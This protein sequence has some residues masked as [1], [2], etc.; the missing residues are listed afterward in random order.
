MCRW[1][2]VCGCEHEFLPT[3]TFFIDINTLIRIVFIIARRDNGGCELTKRYNTLYA[4]E[5]SVTR[6]IVRS[7]RL[8][9]TAQYLMLA[10]GC[11]AKKISKFGRVSVCAKLFMAF[12]DGC[13]VYALFRRFSIQLVFSLLVNLATNDGSLAERAKARGRHITELRAETA[14]NETIKYN[15]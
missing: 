14:L 2:C 1:T 6:L 10:A 3:W 9:E 12:H 4:F 13:W 5:D 11:L 15:W 7:D 8:K